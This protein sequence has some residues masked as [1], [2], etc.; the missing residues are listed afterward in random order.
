MRRATK[1]AARRATTEAAAVVAPA[2][3]VPVTEWSRI[4]AFGD[5][6]GDMAALKT[7]L[8]IAGVIDRESDLWIAEAGTLLVSCGD[9]LDVGR[10]DWKCLKFLR[11]LKDQARDQGG[12]VSLVLGNHEILNILGDL[13]FA[14]PLAAYDV[15]EDL[16]RHGSFH[17]GVTNATLARAKAFKPGGR[18][19]RMIADLCGP[20]P[21]VLVVGDVA[22]CH[23]GL[24]A[25]ALDVDGF[26]GSAPSK[27]KQLNALAADWLSGTAKRIPAALVP[28]AVSPVW[29]R[30]YSQPAG[31]EPQTHVCDAARTALQAL[32]CTRMVIGHTPQISAGVNAACCGAVYRE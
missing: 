4:V 21:V 5:I 23:G 2:R 7:C 32:E 20:S 30:A 24:V 19:A 3:I 16:R 13:R 9:V 25:K 8:R 22:F 17:S 31:A 11:K 27:L 29:N 1:D 15:L 6:H 14:N 28:S 26:R 10:D 18:G 12:D